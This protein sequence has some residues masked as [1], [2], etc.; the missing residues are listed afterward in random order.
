[1]DFNK[2][3][4]IIKNIVAENTGRSEEEQARKKSTI[5]EL[6]VKFAKSFFF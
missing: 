6:Q 5:I 1:M 3:Q 2:A 4:N